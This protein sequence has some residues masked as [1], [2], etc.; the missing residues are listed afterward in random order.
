MKET[1]RKLILLG[2]VLFIV[3]GS[4]YTY[5]QGKKQDKKYLEDLQG[6][7][8]SLT[9][10]QEGKFDY[11]KEELAKL[12][13][14]YPDQANITWN[15]GLVYAMDRDFKKAALYYQKAVDQRP[16]IVQ[17]PMFSLQFAE[18]LFFKEE[19]TVSKQ[20]LEH[21]KK[22]G[23]PEEFNTRVDELLAYIETIK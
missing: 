17:E 20:Y 1:Y 10:I 13:N 3:V 12:H 16:F 4:I 15:L 11:S 5:K 8:I 14:T 19:Y 22:I 18:I 21:L 9:E 23:V 7:H 6:Y 2:L